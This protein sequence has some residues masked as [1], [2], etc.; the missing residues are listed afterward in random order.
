MSIRNLVYGHQN[1]SEQI[2]APLQPDT[3]RSLLD[4]QQF[5]KNRIQGHEPTFAPCEQQ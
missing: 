1:L 4:S 2:A 5:A 3:C